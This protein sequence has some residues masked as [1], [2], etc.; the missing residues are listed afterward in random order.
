MHFLSQ[1]QVK[2]LAASPENGWKSEAIGLD[3]PPNHLF[4]G[5][6]GVGREAISSTGGNEQIP[7]K[8]MEGVRRKDY[9]TGVGDEVKGGI[10]GGEPGEKRRVVLEA[11]RED[12]GMQLV[13]LGEGS[14]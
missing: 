14:L 8:D 13:A 7:C 5:E 11:K 4:V 6:E 10:E 3:A 9:S 2:N 12:K 1:I